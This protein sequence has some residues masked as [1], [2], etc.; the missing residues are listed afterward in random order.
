MKLSYQKSFDKSGTVYSQTIRITNNN[1][2]FIE[3]VNEKINLDLTIIEMKKVK[4]YSELKMIMYLKPIKEGVNY[5]S[6]TTRN[7]IFSGI[8]GINVKDRNT[9]LVC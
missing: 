3:L 6:S 4:S 8:I 2:S 9:V 1:K 7:Y 5:L